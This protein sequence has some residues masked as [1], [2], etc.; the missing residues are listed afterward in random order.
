ML[1]ADIHTLLDLDLIGIDPE[2]LTVVVAEQLRGTCYEE[3]DGQEL[4]VPEDA[5]LA[6][7]KEALQQR[8]ERFTSE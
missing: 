1:R 3:M 2:S 8:W 7:N 5:A 4:I 6:P